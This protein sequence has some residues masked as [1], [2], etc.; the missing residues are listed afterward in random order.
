MQG[1]K[2]LDSVSNIPIFA[3]SDVDLLSLGTST[4]RKE[5][6]QHNMGLTVSVFFLTNIEVMVSRLRRASFQPTI[7]LKNLENQ[8]NIFAAQNEKRLVTRATDSARLHSWKWDVQKNTLPQ[9]RRRPGKNILTQMSL[10]FWKE[11]SRQTFRTSQ[12][13]T[14]KKQS[15]KQSSR[16]DCP[17]NLQITRRAFQVSI[18]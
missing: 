8:K 4:I 11:G 3:Y 12:K 13:E 16:W 6:W 15:F 1:Y 14:R 9:T 2:L 7:F 17:M 10:F 5:L 18:A